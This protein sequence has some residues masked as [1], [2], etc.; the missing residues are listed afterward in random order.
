MEQLAHW[1]YMGLAQYPCV[2][3]PSQALSQSSEWKALP[4]KENGIV[5]HKA[6]AQAFVWQRLHKTH[7]DVSPSFAPTWHAYHKAMALGIALEARGEETRDAK[8]RSR[9]LYLFQGVRLMR[10]CLC[11]LSLE[12]PYNWDR[13]KPSQL[14]WRGHCSNTHTWW[15][16]IL[17]SVRAFASRWC[18]VIESCGW[19]CLQQCTIVL[20]KRSN[21][22]CIQCDSARTVCH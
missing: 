11:A 8:M 4:L 14:K 22:H 3:F 7:A 18:I 17:G 15:L 19:E 5:S 1:N 13:K 10:M 16:F 6:S 21:V 2:A 12:M 9:G 20:T